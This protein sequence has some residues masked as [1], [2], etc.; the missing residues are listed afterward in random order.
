MTSIGFSQFEL[1]YLAYITIGLIFFTAGILQGFSGFGNALIA[2]SLLPLFIDIKIVVPLVAFN[3]LFINF[4]NFYHHRG[5]F[6][7]KEYSSLLISAIAGIPIGVYLLKNIDQHTIE[8]ILGIFLILFS[9]YMLLMKKTDLSLSQY[10]GYVFGFVSGILGGAFNMNGPPVIVYTSLKYNE[11]NNVKSL[12]S[13]YF[14][15]SGLLILAMFTIMG[16]VNTLVIRYFLSFVIPTLLGTLIG[17]Y[18][19]NKVNNKFFKYIVLTILLCMGLI[20]LFK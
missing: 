18:F 10:W 11:K 17:N 8:S 12:L 2:M 5:N 20:Q 9:V 13:S 16:L 4:V 14:F 19:C 1:T 7:R 15:T 6:N 3:S